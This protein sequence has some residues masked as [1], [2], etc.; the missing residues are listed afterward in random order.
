M[1]TGLIS[2]VGLSFLVSL[3]TL[4][5]IVF[6]QGMQD[7]ISTLKEI[8]VFQFY[9]PFL[10]TFSILYA[11]FLKAKVFG[12]NKGLVT[13][14]AL[15]AS[16]FIMIYTP[17]GITFSQF[18]TNFVGNTVVVIFTIV[19]VLLFANLLTE[20][21]IDISKIFGEKNKPNIGTIAIAGLLLLLVVFG[22]FI[23]SGGS[24]IFPGIKLGAKPLFEAIGGV[25]TTT[26][27][28]IVLIFGTALI[29]WLFAKG[30]PAAQK[31]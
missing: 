7:L 12:E 27:A 10:L 28:I 30:Q 24:T 22:V 20:G 26:L 9:L 4:S 31:A 6:A 1:R 2:K 21:G 18:L 8:G 17:V 23:A 15:A 11:L 25:S 5:G 19:M 3:L 14:I 29:V 16:A 13:I